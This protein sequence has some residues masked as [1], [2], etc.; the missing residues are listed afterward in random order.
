M[1]LEVSDKGSAFDCSSTLCGMF[2]S[3]YQLS[4]DDVDDLYECTQTIEKSM[5]E[6]SDEIAMW[7]TLGVR[8]LQNGI[9]QA[10][11]NFGIRLMIE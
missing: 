1:Q 11:A 4:S 5:N 6:V 7:V 3:V 9:Q 2:W 10:T 8:Y